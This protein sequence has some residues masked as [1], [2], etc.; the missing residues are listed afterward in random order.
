MNLTAIVGFAF[1]L[2][3]GIKAGFTPNPCSARRYIASDG[4]RCDSLAEKM[5]DDFLSEHN[6]VHERSIPYLGYNKFRVDFVIDGVFIEYFGRVGLHDYDEII[7]RKKA[8]CQQTNIRLIE[9]YPLDVLE[10]KKLPILLAEFIN[11]KE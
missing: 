5:I 11:Q 4:H 2:V 9:L 7:K 6:V 8:L 3:A 10:K 1:V